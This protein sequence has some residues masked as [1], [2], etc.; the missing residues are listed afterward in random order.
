MNFWSLTNRF[1]SA[2][3]A[4]SLC[5]ATAFGATGPSTALTADQIMKKTIDRAE[6]IRTANKHVDYSY[7]KFSVTEEFDGKGKLTDKKE[8]VLQYEA[9]YGRLSALKL[10]GRA[11]SGAEFRKQDEAAIH[12]RQE[13]TDSKSNRRDDNWEKYLTRELVAKYSFKLVGHENVNGRAA[14]VVAFEPA[15]EN[16]PVDHFIDRLT[17]RLGGKVWIDEEDFEIARAQIAL[18]SEVNLWRGV[19]GNLRKCNFT[20]E[21]SRVDDNIW[22]NTLTNGEFEGRK[23]LEPTH[24]RTRSESTNFKKILQRTSR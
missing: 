2:L 4:V 5:G 19:L 24:V 17:N 1:A 14:F 10:N 6:T 18:R 9:G 20:V 21:R 16:L 12:A 23:L 15:R 13:V 11:I 7:T 3:A 8:K 22:F